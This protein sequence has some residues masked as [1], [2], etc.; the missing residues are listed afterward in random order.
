[1]PTGTNPG[2]SLILLAAALLLAAPASARVDCNEG[3]EPLDQEAGARISAQDFARDVAAKEIA[4]ARAFGQFAYTLEVVIQ[5]L[6]DDAVDG[7]LRQVTTYSFDERGMRRESISTPSST[8]TR[9]K[10]TDKELASFRETLPFVLTTSTALDRDIVYVGRQRTTEFNA[11][12]FDIV[13]RTAQAEERGFMGRVWVRARDNAIAR[14][15][16]VDAMFPVGF[17]RFEGL[18]TPVA[19]DYYMPAHIR[20]DE[21]ARLK[22]GS[23][24]HVRVNARYSDYRAK[25]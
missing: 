5:T 25:P 22:D 19:G 12:V 21:K 10:V 2:T 18:R 8:L 11:T 3:M 14:T 20:A 24:V 16:G 7:E 13:P 4:T 23:R 9:V 6:Q 15:C 17:M 1:M